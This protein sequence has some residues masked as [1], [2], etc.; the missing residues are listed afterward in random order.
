MLVAL[1]NLYVEAGGQTGRWY[2]IDGIHHAVLKGLA[3]RDLIQLDAEHI[4]GKI[5]WGFALTDSGQ[6]FVTNAHNIDTGINANDRKRET[7]AFQLDHNREE[8]RVALNIIAELKDHREFTNRIVQLL[9]L[10][11]ALRSCDTSLLEEMYPDCWMDLR[12]ARENKFSVSELIAEFKYHMQQP[13][14]VEQ[15]A[16]QAGGLQPLGSA[17]QSSSA[18][19]AS[20]AVPQ[21]DTPTYD[22]DEFDLQVTEAKSD[23]SAALNFIASM[24]ALQ[25]GK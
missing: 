8:H 6:S 9:K 19:I 16:G 4:D 12:P 14:K 13:V 20:M 11:Q 17:P 5:R 2:S 25:G 1:Q 18:G 21:F 22:D 7:V 24:N 3:R 23:G 10:D 15:L